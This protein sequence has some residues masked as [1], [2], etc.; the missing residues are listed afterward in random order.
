MNNQT[1]GWAW[2]FEWI[3]LEPGAGS[4]LQWYPNPQDTADALLATGID[5]Q[6]NRITLTGNTVFQNLGGTIVAQINAVDTRIAAKNITLEGITTINNNFQVLLDGSIR[7]NNGVFTGEIRADSGRV[8]GFTIEAGQMTRT[9]QSNGGGFGPVLPPMTGSL[10]LHARGISFAS[11]LGVDE[12]IVELHSAGLLIENTRLGERSTVSLT[13]FGIH[14]RRAVVSG[15]GIEAD[16][17]TGN[18]T[19]LRDHSTVYWLC[20]NTS[21]ITITLPDPSVA[22]RGA[23]YY[24]RRRNA[25]AVT[26]TCV[27]ANRFQ[28]NGTVSSVPVGEGAGDLAVL[29]NVGGF[30][31]YNY[32]P[33]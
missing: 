14:M 25:S 11:F 13:P 7:A 5:I 18:M 31:C 17:V 8:G 29:V 30:W 3:K 6:H 23:M 19:I 33:R 28:R 4:N 9:I 12:S 15:L 32:M 16:T 26:I 10:S 1:A 27:A 22:Q 24:F 21:A 2:S 20:N